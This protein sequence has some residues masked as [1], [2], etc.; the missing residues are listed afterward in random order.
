MD[1]S[2]EGVSTHRAQ[3]L[4]AAERSIH[5]EWSIHKSDDDQHGQRG[6]RG[7]TNAES[8]L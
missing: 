5:V 6:Q 3:R 4:V 1:A 8:S 2:V 7:E